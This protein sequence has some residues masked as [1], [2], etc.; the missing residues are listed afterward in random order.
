MFSLSQDLVR[1]LIPSITESSNTRLFDHL[2]SKITSQIKADKYGGTRKEWNEVS[3]SIMGLSEAGRIRVQEDLAEGLERNLSSLHRHRQQ[4][5]NMWEEDVPIKMDNLPQHVNFLLNL[6]EKPTYQTLAFAYDYIHRSAPIGPT[7]EQLLYQQIMEED[8]FDPGEVWDEEVRHGWT[9][10]D[11]DGMSDLSAQSPLED[12]LATPSDLARHIRLEAK[13]Q[14]ERARR[15]EAEVKGKALQELAKRL[16]NGYWKEQPEVEIMRKGLY[17][18]KEMTTDTSAAA[19][20]KSFFPASF[21]KNSSVINASQLQREL[22]FALSGRPGILFIFDEEADCEIISSHP[23]VRTFSSGALEDILMTIRSYAGQASKLRL[24]VQKTLQSPVPADPAGQMH[25]TSKTAE[26]FA[27]ATRE[28]LEQYDTWLSNLEASFTLGSRHGQSSS[29]VTG[30]PASTTPLLLIHELEQAHAPILRYVSEFVPYAHSPTLLLNLIYSATV[31]TRQTGRTFHIASSLFKLFYRS[32]EPMW[33]MLGIWLQQG[34]P[35]P[36]SLTQ[37]EQMAFS[38]ISLDDGERELDAE[39]FIKRDRDV[40]WA[41][42]DF[43]ECGFVVRDEGWPMWMGDEMGTM[44]MEAGKAQGLLRSLMGSVNTGIVKEWSPLFGILVRPMDEFASP[45]PLGEMDIVEQVVGYLQ[46]LCQ[47]VHFHLRRVLD[48]E[49]GLLQHLEAIEGIMLL[50]GFEVIAEWTEGLF[51]KIVSG[52]PWSDF[53]LLTSSIRTVAEARQA[54]W[55]NPNALRIRTT[56]P[57]G[58]YLGPRALG[59]I[60]ADYLVP[61]PLSQIFTETSI[62]IRSEVFTF[63]LQLSMGR[64]ILARTKRTDKEMMAYSLSNDRRQELRG[65]WCMRGKL[66]WFLDSVYSWLTGRVI[67]DQIASFRVKLE[68]LTSLGLMINLELEHARK[69]R[70]YCFLNPASSDLL[71][72][73]FGILDIACTLSDSFCSFKAQPTPDKTPQFVTKRRR[74]VPRPQKD[75]SSDEE[76]EKMVERPSDPMEERR[77]FPGEKANLKEMERGLQCC[78]SV[79]KHGVEKLGMERDG[80]LWAELGIALEEWREV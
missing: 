6:A 75:L 54:F 23:H 36:L 70:K 79:I 20:A 50:R 5:K 53:Q 41:D 74:R 28:V 78:V 18:W 63:L 44:I 19:V 27:E 68:E 4:G 39:F 38:S 9:D 10:S 64:W 16:K 3:R 30:V 22:I 37:P 52:E 51:K 33:S 77:K 24:F 69:L 55:M 14:E 67:E 12:D 58:V 35:V 15:E 46:P 40:S 45:V 80:E 76:I 65:L 57:Q 73:I 32:A 48:E 66:I 56:K 42:E 72:A 25:A 29:S 17:G 8:P 62:A 13:E 21:S 71:E 49:C 1:S 26:A 59:G 31:N 11:T 34:M 43:W 2:S 60:H 7:P 47:L 61:F